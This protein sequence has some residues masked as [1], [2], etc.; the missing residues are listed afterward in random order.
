MPDYLDLQFHASGQVPGTDA[1]SRR[2]LAG[3]RREVR[4]SLALAFGRLLTESTGE[5]FQTH[6]L[7]F[8]AAQSGGGQ[9]FDVDSAGASVF[10]AERFAFVNA[11]CLEI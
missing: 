2:Y 5:Q 8:R 7:K 11:G 10:V 1:D 3:R 6:G 4:A 9:R